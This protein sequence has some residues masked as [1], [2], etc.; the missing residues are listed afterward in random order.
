MNTSGQ[1]FIFQSLIYFGI[2]PTKLA[3]RS[4][5]T[6]LRN[7]RLNGEDLGAKQL[8]RDWFIAY[9][10]NYSLAGSALLKSWPAFQIMKEIASFPKINFYVPHR[11]KLCIDLFIAEIHNYHCH[12]FSFWSP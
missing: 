2:H 10:M 9:P 3:R 7:R 12:R 5:E 8:F 4:G 11:R 1:Y 6:P